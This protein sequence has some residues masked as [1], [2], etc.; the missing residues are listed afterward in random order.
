MAVAAAAAAAAAAEVK[1]KLF[2][3]LKGVINLCH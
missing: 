3:E 1:F 2:D